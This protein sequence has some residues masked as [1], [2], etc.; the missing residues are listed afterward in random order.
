MLDLN[1]KTQIAKVYFRL[2]SMLLIHFRESERKRER[3]RE[4]NAR[5]RG[6]EEET[7]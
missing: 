7:E 5:E 4:C 3:E 6:R 2:P 1:G